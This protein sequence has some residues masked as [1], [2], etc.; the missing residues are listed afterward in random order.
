VIRSTVLIDPAGKIAH[1]WAKVKSRGHAEK[2]AEKL[3][4]LQGAAQS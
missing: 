1:H 4:E 3:A 2:V